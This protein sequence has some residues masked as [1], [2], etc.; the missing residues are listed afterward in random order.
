MALVD[1]P[2]ENCCKPLRHTIVILNA[3]ITAYFKVGRGRGGRRHEYSRWTSTVV[4]ISHV[5]AHHFCNQRDVSNLGGVIRI[6]G[7]V[8][9]SGRDHGGATH[10]AHRIATG[11]E[12][13]EFIGPD[14]KCISSTALGVMTM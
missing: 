6:I 3:C 12:I 4:A 2:D 9:E 8:R 7:N 14:E 5:S 13:D 11:Y 1:N 10:G